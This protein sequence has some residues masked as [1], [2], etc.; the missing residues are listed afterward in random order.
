MTTIINKQRDFL[1]KKFHILCGKA[2]LKDYE[3]SAMVES[4]GK[5]SSSDLTIQD[6]ISAV[7]FLEK[8]INPDLVEI[9][10][11]RKRVIASIGGFLKMLKKEQNLNEIKA[12]ACRALEY[13]K[14]NDIPKQ[15]LINVYY[16][17]VAKQK[18]MKSSIRVMENEIDIMTILN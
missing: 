2:E 3:K 14:F 8:K 11:W 12:I 16:A 1:L 4:Y 15:R 18:D 13:E 7:D 9:D 17:F 5:T 10:K 6:L